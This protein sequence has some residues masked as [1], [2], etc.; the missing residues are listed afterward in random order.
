MNA[1]TKTGLPN[2]E[3]Y[4]PHHAAEPVFLKAL[5]K[6]RTKRDVGTLVCAALAGLAIAALAAVVILTL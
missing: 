3:H 5:P 1:K 4:R 6:F 2:L